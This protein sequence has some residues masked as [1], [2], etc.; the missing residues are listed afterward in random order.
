LAHRF[1]FNGRLF[2]SNPASIYID[3]RSPTHLHSNSGGLVGDGE[4]GLELRSF[5]LFVDYR[6]LR[7]DEAGFFEH[8][9]DFGFAEA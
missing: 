7:V 2:G 6:D 1:R 9:F 5:L 4:E 8:G 3:T